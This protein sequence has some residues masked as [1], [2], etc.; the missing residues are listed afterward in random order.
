MHTLGGD[1]E[2]TITN[3]QWCDVG[4]RASTQSTRYASRH[5]VFPG[6]GLIFVPHGPYFCQVNCKPH[7]NNTETAVEK[8]AKSP[9][10][11]VVAQVRIGAVLKMADYVPEIQEHMRKA[12][13]D[14]FR[15]KEV[16]QLE[17]GPGGPREQVIHKWGFDRIEQTTGFVVQAESVIFHTTTYDTHETFFAELEQ[18]LQ[19]VQNALGISAA[20]RFGVR[21]VDA[22]QAD[23]GRELEEYLKEG[24]CGVPL[25]QIGARRSLLFTN[26]ISDTDVGG[27]LVVRIGVNSD[28]TLPQNLVPKDLLLGRSFDSAH[29]IAVL[30]YDHFIEKPEPFSVERALGRF[31]ELHGILS[32]VF[33][34]TVSDVALE[35]WR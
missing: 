33:R 19:I 1:R 4:V 12:G 32:A 10:I 30:D 25:A 22:F 5:I 21:Y 13:Y 20:E 15:P 28:G 34:E 17:F 26:L 2:I 6:E 3:E 35:S 29:P 23:V 14:L 24:L 18:G 9:L 31:N 7:K 27:R 8:L 16:R 11:Y